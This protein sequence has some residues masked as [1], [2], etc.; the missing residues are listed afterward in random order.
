MK[1]KKM[2]I[3]RIEIKVSAVT[4]LYRFSIIINDPESFALKTLEIIKKKS[5]FVY[6]IENSVGCKWIIN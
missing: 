5:H 2:M 6:Y 3:F 4:E 1:F